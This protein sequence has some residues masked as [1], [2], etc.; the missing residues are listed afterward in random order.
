MIYRVDVSTRPGQRDARGEQLRD[1]IREL[2][3]EGVERVRVSDIYFLEGAL[4]DAMAARVATTL[5]YDPVVDEATWR[6]VDAQREEL[7][8]AAGT[9]VVEVALLPGVTDSVAES[10]LEGAR[11]GGIEGIEEAASGHRYVLEG[12]LD[13]T[14]VRRI[15]GG[16]LANEVVQT[17][18]VQRPV[19]PPFMETAPVNDY[20]E[21]VPITELDDDGLLAVSQERRLSLDIYE[22]RAIQEYYRGESREPTDAE[23]EMLAQTW[24][25]HCVHKTFRARIDFESRGP[26]GNA[27]RTIESLL[28]TYIKGATDKAA[29]PWTRSVFVDNA[30]IV[31][32]DDAY[33]LAFKVETH[34][35]PSALEP[36]GGSNTGVGGVV[37][38][39][40]GVSARPI[41]NTDILCFG[42]S[43]LPFRELPEG[44]LH[45]RRI[46]A[47]VTHGIEDYGNK[48]GI[49]TVSGAILY[50]P[51][52]TANPLVYCGC[53]GLLPHG[54]H[55]RDPQKGDLVIVIGGR[56]GRDGLRGAT[57]SSMEMDHTTGDV[58]GSAVQIGHPIHEKQC[59]EVVLKARD[60]GLYTAITD[61]GAGGLSS[62]VGEMGSELGAE[63]HIERVPV[64]YRGLQPWEVWL[65]EA[66]ERMVLAVPPANWPRVKEIC[67]GIDVEATEIG[68]FTGDGEL[69]LLFDGKT[70]GRLNV[71]FL[72]DGVPRMELKALWEQ[73]A[74]APPALPP[75]ADLGGTILDLLASPD[76]RSK[77]HV[78]RRYDHEVQGGTLVKPF[79]GP[80]NGG[81][82]D[83]AVLR[84][85]AAMRSAGP[86][87]PGQRGVAIACGINPGYGKLDPYAM[88]WTAVDESIRNVV[89][90]G[91]D[92]DRVSLLD[93]FCWGNPRL[94]DRLG[95]LVRAVEGCHDAAVAFG[96]P[97]ISGKDSLNNEY[98][99]A[100][101]TK[102]AIPGTI[103]ISSMAIVPDV[104]RTTTMD[105]KAA[106]DYVYAV[107]TTRNELGMSAYFKL[108]GEEGGVAP[109]VVEEAPEL[110]RALHRAIL[111]GLVSACHDC[112]EGG[113]A[114][115]AAEMALGGRRGVTVDLLGAPHSS[116]IDRDDLL[117]FSESNGRFLVTVSPENA[118]AFE[119]ALSGH[120]VARIGVVRDDERVVL[121]GAGGATL[122][123]VPVG[124]LETAFR[125][126]VPGA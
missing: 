120:A 22:M 107:G 113:I 43:D 94:P 65:S 44:V 37:R 8:T 10:L 84:P 59:L 125:G 108:R 73:P 24:S 115:A 81:P 7:T 110:Y 86:P 78:V 16:L 31:E 30:G 36:F 29:K 83:A 95:S 39:V 28:K 71:D 80:A 11:L 45:P 55:P 106:G 27:R 88:A 118:A 93:N 64:K 18:S 38:D 14:T 60:E 34:N 62:A 6:A 41:A 25:E 97:F 101:G 109:G 61:C 116:D 102:H 100:D 52:Y 1:Q 50:D 74:P 112:S 57:F 40:I 53:V 99:A 35:H 51:G 4:D 91:A 76:I 9:W 111:Q 114:L 72:H 122:A 123:D 12:R 70:V 67:D 77:E 49:P 54:S 21:V 46:E 98:T 87:A 126:H 85:L 121:H 19:A 117:A 26:D 79:V 17:Y 58:A 15:A 2:G 119:A 82:G 89:A 23:L 32:F 103:L 33:D 75:T 105:L 42:P 96:A 69:R 66:Q 68:H 56:T 92:P 3:I 47:G 48:M 124:E 104:T 20:V 13:D 63:V 90:V 5:L